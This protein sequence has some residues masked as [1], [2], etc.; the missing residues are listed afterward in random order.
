M[1][2]NPP[3]RSAARVVMV[4]GMTLTPQFMDEIRSRLTLSDVI[5][6]RLKLTRAG[7]EF[8]AC[9]PFHKEKSPSFYVND[10]KQFFHCF[11]CG[12][13]GDVIGF[14]MRYDNLSFPEAAEKLAASAGLKMPETSADDARHASAQ[15]NFYAVM[16]SAALWFEAQLALPKN[17]AVMGYLTGR[18]LSGTTIQNFRLGYAPPDDLALYRHLKSAGFDEAVMQ[19]MGL[20][21]TREKDGRPYGFFRER[22]MFPVCDR[23]GRVIAFG[24]RIL[25]DKLRDDTHTRSDFKPPKY[26]N[27]PETPLFHKGRNVY[28]LAQARAAIGKDQ[29]PVV[30]EGYMDVIACHQAGVTGAIAPLGTAL[31]EDQ[32]TL[33]WKMIPRPEKTITLCFDGDAAGQAA[34]AR[35]ALRILPLLAPDHSARIAFLPDGEDPDTLIAGRG[36]GAFREILSQGQGLADY[37]WTQAAGRRSLTRPEDRAGLDSELDGL[38]QH[39][40]DLKTRHHYQQFF[41]D[42]LNTAF[43]PVFQKGKKPVLPMLSHDPLKRPKTAATRTVEVLLATLLL[44]PAIF[45]MV[46]EKLGHIEIADENYDSLRQEMM[47]IL[48]T[49][50]YT[51]SADFCAALTARDPGFAPLIHQLQDARVMVH[52]GFA[53]AHAEPNDVAA[54]WRQAYD[55]YLKSTRQAG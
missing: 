43:R 40:K 6:A 28:A 8:K 27:S 38:V 35:A 47:D 12:A 46:D 14:V 49:S 23:S 10:D 1:G 5:G 54:G 48:S 3:L 37:L 33:L 20:I 17:D 55:S 29:D 31:T 26:L 41:R 21:K 39:I 15:K 30:V 34:A 16:E 4:R 52:A 32:I 44:H 25:P 2:A 22:V 45:E 50:P 18:G 42:K 13:H 24:G 53:R 7:R 11:G 9:C 51:D 19:H 36:V